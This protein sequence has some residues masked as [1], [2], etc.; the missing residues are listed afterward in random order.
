MRTFPALA[1][2]LALLFVAGCQSDTGLSPDLSESQVAQTSTNDLQCRTYDPPLFYSFSETNDFSEGF[3]NLIR[4]DTKTGSATTI[5]HL[6]IANDPVTGEAL[7]PFGLTF[8]TDGTMYTIIS[9]LDFIEGHQKSRLA[10]VDMKTGKVKYIGKYIPLH[11]AGPEMDEHGNIYATSF[12]VGDPA[13][14]PPYIF[15]DNCLYRFNKSTGAATLI[16]NTGRGDWMDLAFDSKGKL[17][18]TTK[19]KLFI[20]NTR[21]GAA[22]FV[23]DIIGVPNT[24]QHVTGIPSVDWP[25]MEVMT[26]AFDEHDGLWATAMRGFS[27]VLGNGLVLKID[28]STGKATV[29]GYTNKSY[30]HGGDIL[31]HKGPAVWEDR[32]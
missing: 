12:T 3:L 19:N 4:I 32:D 23:R 27:A 30:N 11:F 21:T 10:R 13:G 18:A 9:W 14:G 17:W 15:G 25:Y 31:L 29:V 6:G 7:S 24:D 28:V 22:T 8:D 20:L 16:G 26:I 1:V 5:W 2:F